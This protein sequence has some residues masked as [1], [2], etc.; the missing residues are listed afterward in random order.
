MNMQIG[1]GEDLA[2]GRLAN[3]MNEILKRT[4]SRFEWIDEQLILKLPDGTIFKGNKALKLK[5]IDNYRW[6]S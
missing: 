5:L 6:N 3:W 1:Y 4:S 2:R